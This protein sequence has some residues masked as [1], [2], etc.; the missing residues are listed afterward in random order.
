VTNVGII[1]TR[2]RN[3]STASCSRS[4]RNC[5]SISSVSGL[6]GTSAPKGIASS[7]SSGAR[8]GMTAAIHGVKCAPASSGLISGVRPA[9]GRKSAEKTA[10][11]D[12]EEY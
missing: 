3:V 5:G 6:G 8:S 9:S 12:A 10:Y 11:G 1:K 4:R 2:V 7:G